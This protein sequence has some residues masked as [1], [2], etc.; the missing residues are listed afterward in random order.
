M[1]VNAMVYKLKV[2]TAVSSSII[3]IQIT[4]TYTMYIL[5]TG[6]NGVHIIYFCTLDRILGSIS[7]SGQ[8]PTYPSPNPTLTLTCC[9]LTVVELGEG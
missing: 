2:H 7:V 5:K 6:A 4:K 8:L 1:F 3:L 9:Q